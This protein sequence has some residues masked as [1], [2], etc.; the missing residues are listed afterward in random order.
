MAGTNIINVFIAD[1]HSVLIDGLRLVVDAESDM[2]LIGTAN[3]GEEA[4]E[5]VT[6]KDVNVLLA[7]VNLPGMS[8]IELCKALQKRFPDIKVVGLSTYDKP[9][10]IKNM[11]RS[12]ASGYVLKN[13]GSAEVLEAIRTVAKGE[14]YLSNQANQVLVDGL[15]NQSKPKSG[16]VPELTR[17]EKQVLSLIADEQTT[18][19]IAEALFISENTVESHRKNLLHKFNVKNVAG[20]IRRSMEL[21]MIE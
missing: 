16:F 6:G 13:A 12:G 4:L 2:R 15:T 18:P 8:G 10:V 14:I 3:S 1:D 19:E 7:D 20:L 5:A 11:L 21:G 9:S 17:R